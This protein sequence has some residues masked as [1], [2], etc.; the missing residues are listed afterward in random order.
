MVTL[1]YSVK[2]RLYH[3]ELG[4]TASKH[5]P[6]AAHDYLQEYPVGRKLQIRFRQVGESILQGPKVE[7][8]APYQQRDVTVF[9]D[10]LHLP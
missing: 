3:H 2:G 5:S 1:E 4:R 7:H 9:R 8:G 6:S 10:R